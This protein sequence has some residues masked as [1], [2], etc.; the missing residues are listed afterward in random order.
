MHDNLPT[1]PEFRRKICALKGIP[2]SD[3]EPVVATPAAPETYTAAEVHKLIELAVNERMRV[4]ELR[5]KNMLTDQ[6]DLS[7]LRTVEDLRWRVRD[8]ED[9]LTKPLDPRGHLPDLTEITKIHVQLFD[10]KQHPPKCR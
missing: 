6:K 3:P 10:N 7:L 5:I 4:F 9:R 1:D 8:L 2:Y